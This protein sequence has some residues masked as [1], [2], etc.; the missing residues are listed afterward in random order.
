LFWS[1]T[2]FFV[3]LASYYML[4]PLRDQMG[5]AAGVK[6][7]P[8][9]F[10]ATFLVMLVAQPVYG[11]LVARV[12]RAR[13]IPIVYQFFVLNLGVFW[14]L[15]H[16]NI[17]VK[18]VAQVFFVWISVFNLFAVSVFWSFMADLFAR[19]QFKRLF[20][21]IAAGGTAG[22]LISPLAAIWLAKPLGPANLLVIAAVLLETAVVC[23]LFLE[24]AVPAGRNA[25][26]APSEQKRGAAGW[27]EG[28][29][30]IAGSRYLAANAAWM[31]F[32]SFAGTMVYL[33]QA[34]LVAASVAD[35]A[36]QI[37]IF[38]TIDLAAAIIT[39]LVQWIFTGKIMTRF[40]TAAALAFQPIV[41]LLGFAILAVSP[42]LLVVLA[43]QSLQGAAGF[44]ISN[45]ARQVLFTVVSRDDKYKAKNVIDV[46]VFRGSD[47]ASSGIFAALKSLG[48]S[49]E[50]VAAIGFA[51]SIFWVALSLGLGRSEERRAK[52]MHKPAWPAGDAA[53]LL[54]AEQR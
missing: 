32:L 37:R 19:E 3:L 28:F 4:R 29:S 7:L 36:A 9:L 53:A 48:Q 13:F 23:I 45:P 35:T 18:Q 54:A 20:G 12:S 17:A 21:V 25:L 51:I 49:I 43:F 11:A 46:V 10:S 52:Q 1:F 30:R 16:Y 24:R 38:A 39:L 31:M 33:E 6:N 44:A 26:L 50:A 40:G 5:I 14:V 42:A 27:L 34:N 2:Y 41:F 47:A 15:L 22:S 8:Y